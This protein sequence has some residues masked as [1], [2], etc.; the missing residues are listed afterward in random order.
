MSRFVTHLRF[1]LVL[2]AL[3]SAVGCSS[4]RD[5]DDECED[6]DVAGVHRGAGVSPAVLNRRLGLRNG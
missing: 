5:Y 4:F 3:S 6:D 2:L 1:A